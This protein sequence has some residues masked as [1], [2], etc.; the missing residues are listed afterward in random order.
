MKERTEVPGRI[1]VISEGRLIT[2]AVMERMKELLEG[3]DM[4]I[5]T[6]RTLDT[7]AR[8]KEIREVFARSA[9]FCALGWGDS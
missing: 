9:D 4:F 8:A 3:Y 7:D 6:G 1:A 5:C 2:G